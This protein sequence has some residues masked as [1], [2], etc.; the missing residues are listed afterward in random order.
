MKF[1]KIAFL[2]LLAYTAMADVFYVPDSLASI[3][4]AIDSCLSGDS[5]IVTDSFQD[6]GGISIDNKS[7]S[8][9]S[10]PYLT[11][12]DSYNPASGA[13]LFQADNSTPII[14]I[15][16]SDSS[17]IKGF[18]ID[19]V[20]IST[21]GGGIDIQQSNDVILEKLFV[22]N[23]SFHVENSSLKITNSKIYDI[24][25]LSSRALELN[26][27]EISIYRTLITNNHNNSL[28]WLENTSELLMQNT[29]VQ[30][31]SS[32]NHL[33]SSSNSTLYIDFSTFT[34]NESSDPT[35][36][37]SQ[38]L[39]N[40]TR[41]IIDQ[42]IPLDTS[43]FKISYSA[44]RQNYSGNGNI[45]EDPALDT[46]A[47]YPYLLES[48]PC[49]SA[50]NKDTVNGDVPETDFLG[51]QRPNPSWSYADMGALE[52]SSYKTANSGH[53]FW[54]S[55][56][57]DDIWGNGIQ[58]TP[59]KSIQAAYDACSEND[60]LLL[61][62]E[63]HTA[64]AVLNAK[65]I[66]LSSTYLLYP[67]QPDLISQTI[68]SNRDT[69]GS[70]LEIKNTDSLTI[71]GISFSDGS[72]KILYSGYTYGGA[73]Y[74]ENSHCNFS[75][76][77]FSNNS[78]V[79]AGG[80]IY[81]VSST[82]NADNI[83]LDSNNAYLGGGIALAQSTLYLTHSRI[84][85]SSA[86]A[87]G[88][89]YANN[90]SKLFAYYCE[91]SNNSTLE[92]TSFQKLPAKAP[93]SIANS[94]GAIFSSNSTI[95]FNN[96]LLVNNRAGSA[97]SAAYLYGGKIKLIQSTVTGN[98]STENNNGAI[99]L[100]NAIVG[101][102]I[103][104]SILWDNDSS[105]VSIK[106]QSDLTVSHSSL[107]RQYG[108][109][110]NPDTI[111]DLI[112]QSPY[113]GDPILSSGYIPDAASPF[114]E[115]G[116]ALYNFQDYECLNYPDSVYNGIAPDLGYLG[117][118]PAVNFIESSS[119]NVSHETLPETFSLLQAY[120]NPFNPTVRLN[121]QIAASGD[122]QIQLYNILGQKVQ[123]LFHQELSSGNYDLPFNLSY[124][125]SAVYICVYRYNGQIM[126]SQK[127]SLVK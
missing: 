68:L 23:N 111:S 18:L 6:S 37:C 59:Y 11:N 91:L 43:Q 7:I 114:L 105:D 39:L 38:S 71:T 97:G 96:G 67:D 102:L 32:E 74:L 46:T 118:V 120:P 101:S 123:N 82:I 15:T 70:I 20:D 28:F 52:S 124:L 127:I 4:L 40:I 79:Y 42:D 3:Q 22:K 13:A 49:F 5:I 64:P 66:L 80:A 26:N 87:G 9:F 44:V 115:K 2:S 72:G 53:R 92:D 54:I 12:P 117:A 119:L 19:A 50:T 89:I 21:H 107:S 126:N 34:S 56:L 90:E 27:S 60:T 73:V 112:I 86:L 103:L 1:V 75:D 8:I 17:V 14:S 93:L 109:I 31:N 121:F 85:G 108:S 98:K 77:V 94:G 57:G 45:M 100:N 116:I 61:T 65:N 51:N 110:F 10:N 88:G 29:L 41:S 99:S 76:L 104:N 84:N 16:Q 47:A 30:E 81:A 35:F 63:T 55:S 58:G 122:I 125:P 62:A 106:Q 78:A 83:N 69:S 25:S 24:D 48:S 95:Y 33:L 36:N 113:Y